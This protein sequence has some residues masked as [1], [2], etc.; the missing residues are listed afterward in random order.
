MTSS[1]HILGTLC[2]R[3]HDHEMTGQS[4]RH[5]R[6][7]TGLPSDCVRCRA[8]G[9][10]ERYAR[11]AEQAKAAARLWYA[12][13]T[14]EVSARNAQ[15]YIEH[16]ESRKRYQALY[17]EQHPDKVAL[18]KQE[19]YQTHKD[20]IRARSSQ[21]YYL[22]KDR[23]RA[24]K[25]ANADRIRLWF[26][27]YATTPKGQEHA[28]KSNVMYRIR[29]S[30]QRGTVTPEHKTRLLNQLDGRCLTCRVPMTRTSRLT[31][32]SLTWDHVV[33]LSRG[34]M[35]DDSNLIPICL[36]CNT[37]KNDRTL[38]EWLG[39]HRAMELRHDVPHTA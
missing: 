31:R 32:T 39:F 15:S 19:Y 6:A 28:R 22:N 37:T 33:P 16:Q 38:I 17:R 12:E 27:V 35:D 13:H 26:R 10:K 14:E 8:E 34:G 9:R 25:V 5:V 21:W 30:S 23:V 36:S 7:G 4:L 20:E 11:E 2:A 1:K 3:G 24:W 29:K 18:R